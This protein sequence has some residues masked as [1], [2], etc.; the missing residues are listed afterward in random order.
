[1]K[2]VVDTLISTMF[3]FAL[4]AC[5]SQ[6][7]ITEDQNPPSAYNDDVTFLKKYSE[8]M[9]LT[10]EESESRI[11]VMPGLQA[12]VMTS[13]PGAPR[14]TSYGWINRKLFQSGDTSLH[15]NA[16]GGEERFWI[17]P[18]GGQFSIY[19]EKDSAFTFENW[20]TPRVID[21]DAYQVVSQTKNAATFS[22]TSMLKNYSGTVFN[23]TIHREC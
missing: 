13:T 3:L 9:E 18:E 22:K 1:M 10:A 21:L 8:V 7:K 11:A 4:A 2:R 15:M 23:I 14:H 17:G 19:F 16:F 12:R 20:H 5:G 6:E